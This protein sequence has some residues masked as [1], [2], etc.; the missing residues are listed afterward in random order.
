MTISTLT[1][2][3]IPGAVI[4]TR[5]STGDQDKNGTSP[6]TQ[7]AACRQK[8]AALGLPIV[9]EYYDGGISGGFL[10]M[11]TEF[12]AAIADIQAGRSNTLICPNISRYSR[13]MEHQQ[14]VKKAVRANIQTS[15][16]HLRHGSQ[17]LEQLITDEWLLVVGAEYSLETGRV[18]FFDRE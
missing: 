7:L 13:D 5:V 11:R 10:L 1:T 18:E 12:Q 6:E 17:V 15:V 9:A 2:P 14:A 4:Y 8:A 16:D 3:R